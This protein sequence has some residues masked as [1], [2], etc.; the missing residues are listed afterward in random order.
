M[1]FSA[2]APST[3]RATRRRL[4]LVP[5]QRGML[6]GHLTD[7]ASPAW[8]VALLTEL[9][10]QVDDAVLAECLRRVSLEMPS[11]RLRFDVSTD[12]AT[13]HV[14]DLTDDVVVTTPLGAADDEAA[15]ARHLAARLAAEPWDVPGGGPLVRNTLL[16]GRTGVWWVQRALH[17]VV[18]GYGAWL[19]RNRVVEHYN[20]LV[21]GTELPDRAYPSVEELVAQ[22]RRSEDDQRDFWREYLQGAPERVSPADRAHH[23]VAR[24][25]RHDVVLPS[26]VRVGLGATVGN[27]VWTYPLIAAGAAYVA[28]VS[29]EDS[30]VVGVPVLGRDTA[31][32]LATTVNM[33]NVLPLRVP[34][35]PD[36]DLASLTRRVIDSARSTRPH[37]QTPTETIFEAV[38]SAWRAGRLHGPT[39]NVMPYDDDPVIPGVTVTTQALQRGPVYDLLL[40][41]HPL[42]D[43]SLAV[44]CEAHREIYTLAQ[45]RWHAERFATFVTRL[46]GATAPLAEVDHR[47]LQEIEAAD[48]L[49]RPRTAR[50]P[51]DAAP[52][53]TW[54]DVVSAEQL[55][56]PGLDASVPRGYE[57]RDALGRT[58]GFTQV[59]ELVAHT[60]S[61][62]VATGQLAALLPDG[63]VVAHG[64]VEGRRQVYGRH[65]EADG[66]AHDVALLDGVESCTATWA[67]RRLSLTVTLT[68]GASEADVARAAK[69]TAPSGTR[70]VV[71]L[72]ALV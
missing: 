4:P 60:A 66:V 5:A 48:E 15:A 21:S 6:Q 23:V 44:E 7:P 58:T 54:G 18:D 33:M 26:S 2:A 41:I 25:H 46:A 59:G 63:R 22:P 52:G 14:A 62:T 1:T 17:A 53:A 12:P 11:L 19:G 13:Q 69:Q 61:G 50:V 24:P 43:G 36:D 31:I 42:A 20:H 47:L 56:V 68:P 40:T 32:D 35:E 64:P 34:V 67:G 45:T 8:G 51:D 65:V 55:T 38:P 37:Q 70:P 27:R 10:G 28:R 39:I 3:D 16:V 57:I 30:A 49:A 72:S 71:H 29:E 9:V